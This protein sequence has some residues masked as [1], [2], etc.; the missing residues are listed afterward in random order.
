MTPTTTLGLIIGSA[1][2]AACGDKAATSDPAP[3]AGMEMPA[4][5]AKTA[6]GSGTVVA[7]DRAAGKITLDHGAIP[8][9]GWPAMTMAF[10]ARPDVLANVAIGD[11]VAFD[12]AVD[13]GGGRVT[14]LRKP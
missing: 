11:K 3:A 9:V 5:A 4:T 1:L 12:L 7:V 14:A 10:A 2:L 13:G 6:K 8:E